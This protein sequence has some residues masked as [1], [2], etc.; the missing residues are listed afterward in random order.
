LIDLFELIYWHVHLC[1][2]M[3]ELVKTAY[4]MSISCFQLVFVSFLG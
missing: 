3:I 2:C 4:D 1:D